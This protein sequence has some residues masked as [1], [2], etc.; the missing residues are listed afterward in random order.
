LSEAK[1]KVD[2]KMWV[3]PGLLILKLK[4]NAKKNF[5]ICQIG[6]FNINSSLNQISL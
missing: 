1:M 6:I 3:R 5:V 2:T 4:R